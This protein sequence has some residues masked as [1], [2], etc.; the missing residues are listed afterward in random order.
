L[1]LRDIELPS[2]VTWI[3]GDRFR[4]VIATASRRGQRPSL[5]GALQGEVLTELRWLIQGEEPIL[6]PNPYGSQQTRPRER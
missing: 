4:Q 6:C 1:G 3:R 2:P 5:R